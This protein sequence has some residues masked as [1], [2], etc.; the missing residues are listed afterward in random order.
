MSQTSNP[1]IRVEVE[2][3]YIEEQSDPREV[4]RTFEEL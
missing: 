1:K 3:A 2:T 4:Q